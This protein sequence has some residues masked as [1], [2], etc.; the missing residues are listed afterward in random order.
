MWK[1]AYIG[2]NLNVQGTITGN[3]DVT[4]DLT[5]LANGSAGAPSIAFKSST[6]SGIFLDTSTPGVAISASGTE[7]LR[8]GA[9]EVDVLQN[10]NAS[11][12]TVSCATV[13]C[14]GTGEFED[15]QTGTCELGTLTVNSGGSII[16]QNGSTSKSCN[17]I[18]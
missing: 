14:S 4:P 7:G 15:V 9:S 1:D 18:F 5:G 2:N 6:N 3:I 8:V 17:P 13:N 16:I 10:L 12:H 11:G